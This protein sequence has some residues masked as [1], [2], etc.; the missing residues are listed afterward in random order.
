MSK[1]N[2]DE[3][4]QLVQSA[5]DGEWDRDK[6]KEARLAREKAAKDREGTKDLISE[7]VDFLGRQKD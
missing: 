3:M 5:M 2:Y 1:A 6:L 4:R 7:A